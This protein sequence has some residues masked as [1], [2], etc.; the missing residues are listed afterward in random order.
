M[1][2]LISQVRAESGRYVVRPGEDYRPLLNRLEPGDE[3]VFLPGEHEGAAILNLEG[4]PQ[5]PIT[6]RGH[7]DAEGQRPVVQF[8]G[9]GHNL[10]RLRGQHVVVRDLE[11]HATH[12]YAI[13]VDRA[14]HVRIENCVFRD[15][16]GGDLSANSANVHALHI[17]NCTFTGS[18][19]TPVYIGQ[20][21]GQLR[22]TDFRFEGNRIDGRRIEGGIGYGIQLKL[23]VTG[24]LIRGNW[25]V[26]TRGPGIMVYGARQE[27]PEVANVVESNVVL[28]ARNNPGIVV[29]GGPARV[30]GNLV[31]G[32][33]QGGIAVIDY[34]GRDL[35]WGV[36]I[37]E[38][39]AVANGAFDL[40]LRGN[41]REGQ[42]EDNRILAR[43]GA[44]GMRGPQTAVDRQR[45][46]SAD[47]AL[48]QRIAR[49]VEREPPRQTPKE[50]LPPGPLSD[51]ELTNWLDRWLA[52]HE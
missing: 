12:A 31:I 40:S 5:R 11:L 13:R 23:N 48:Q 27:D 49:L 36:Q 2:V 20:H 39:T 35:L 4:Q 47:E 37:R 9:R 15:C 51:A 10:W 24:G 1:L 3:L 19:R 38:N 45:V 41:V 22:I 26:G 29:G 42:F 30:T 6:L 7:I 18:R 44:P 46:E 28:A 52:V 43:P 14:D 25:I 17:V 33:P 8:T 21:E 50:L 16:G 32:N 34:G